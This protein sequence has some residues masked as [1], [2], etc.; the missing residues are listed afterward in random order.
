M[1]LIGF[2]FIGQTISNIT[3]LP[4]PGGVIGFM[5]VLALLYCR[6]IRI[7]SLVL[8]AEWFI[9]EML[10]FFIPAVPAVLNHREFLGWMG[11]KVLAIIA[12]GTII[13]MISTAFVVE[14]CMRKLGRKD[15]N[16]ALQ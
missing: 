9:A 1:L 5:L 8:G 10:L 6:I 12:I 14:L 16:E 3:G 11:L 4:I 7:N 13:V 15:G 2:W